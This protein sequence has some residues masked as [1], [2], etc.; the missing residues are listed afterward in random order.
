M[1]L[2]IPII[3]YLLFLVLV[4]M[5]QSMLVEGAI[6][7]PSNCYPMKKILDN[8]TKTQDKLCKAT[9]TPTICPQ[10]KSIIDFVENEYTYVCQGSEVGKGD[11]KVD[12]TDDIKDDEMIP[13]A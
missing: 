6:F 9:P 12:N 2:N 13:S 3:L 10:F 7:S 4:C 1:K 5:N 8:M 11:N